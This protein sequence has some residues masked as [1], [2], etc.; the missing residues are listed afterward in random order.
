MKIIFLGTS[1]ATAMPLPFCNC[2]VCVEARYRRGKD[3]RKRSSMVINNDMLID[4]GPDSVNACSQYGV[5]LPNIKYILQTHAHSDHFDAGHFI[6]RHPDYGTRYSNPVI[7]TASTKTL[8]AINIM[9]KA[10]NPNADIFSEKFQK[11]LKITLCVTSLNKPVLLGNYSIVPLDSLHDIKQESQVYMITYGDKTILYGTDLLSMDRA[12]SDYISPTDV[13]ID[14]LVLD[15]TYGK[16]SN[17][18]GHMDEKQV[19]KTIDQMRELGGINDKTLI[20][21]THI[22]HEGNP[23][24]DKMQETAKKHGYNIAYDGLILEL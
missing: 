13:H 17:A 11:K 18:G 8:W 19:I 23:T 3:I 20:Y 22:S 14:L 6:T 5:D 15:Q 7:L 16:G 1:A 10:E 24:H 12:I 2:E 9:L 21:A 4:L